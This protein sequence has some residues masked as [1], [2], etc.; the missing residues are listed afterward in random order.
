MNHFL[1]IILALICFNHLYSQEVKT[2]TDT[3]SI[4]VGEQIIYS[5]K[6]NV[7]KGDLVLFPKKD[8]FGEF[9]VLESFPIDSLAKE[10]K[11]IQLIKKYGITHFD[12]GRFIIPTTKISINSRSFNTDSIEIEVNN[13]VVDTLKQKMYDIKPITYTKSP[14]SIWTKYIIG[15]LIIILIGILLYFFIK[16][17]QEKSNQL[18]A[19]EYASPIEKALAFFDLLETN[20]INSDNFKVKKHYSDLTS[21]ARTY[22]EEEVKI[23][24]LESTTS[25]LY[26]IL[27]KQAKKKLIS[28]DRN[29]IK[30]FR[31]VLE[32]AD[33][34]KFAKSNPDQ[35]EIEKDTNFIGQFIKQ[36]DSQI[37]R[38]EK[39]QKELFT[40][41]IKKKRQKKQQFLRR[42]IPLST[43]FVLLIGLITTFTL[44]DGLNHL[45]DHYIGHST[46]SL[47]KG[48]WIESEYG[49][50]PITLKTPKALKRQKT[51]I[52]DDLPD[53]LQAISSFGY[54]SLTDRFKIDL[55][56]LA[57]RDSTDIDIDLTI[58]A[59]LEL[60]KQRGAQNIFTKYEGF[61][62]QND[63]TGRKAFGTFTISPD[64]L[65]PSNK[66]KMSFE[67]LVIQQPKGIQQLDFYHLQN[68]KNAK[69]IIE[70]V[71]KSVKLSKKQE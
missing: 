43:S 69:S 32:T 58:Q 39:Q 65:K 44:T 45:R 28:L 7:E 48:K 21:I 26:T 16:K 50:P 63:L 53:N 46:K 6:A 56:T 61:E 22:L 4:R 68:D 41:Q 29:L 67:M 2:T 51:G 30:K 25:E 40:E 70:R 8:R 15:L 35:S 57:F 49:Y 31:S 14:P 17:Q 54:G 11:K 1:R 55:S 9:E 36:F 27:K 64:T 18:H 10:G 33:L 12:S 52:E 19:I 59:K 3:T 23:P 20:Q 66:V 38:E 62:N 34:V 60:L 71:E 47:L 13:V 24:A 42:I 37:P 5:I